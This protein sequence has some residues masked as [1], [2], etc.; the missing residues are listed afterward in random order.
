VSDILTPSDPH[1]QTGVQWEQEPGCTQ[2][3]VYACP[4]CAE[5]NGNTAQAKTPTSGIPTVL[6]LPFTVYRGFKCSPIGTWNE[7][8]DRAKRG[9]ENGE[10]RAV[11]NEIA[12]GTHS[13]SNA[14][15][16]ATTTDIT[17]TPGT[18]VSL[19]QGI[20]LLEQYMATNS[21]GQGVIMMTRRDVTLANA[22][23]PLIRPDGSVLRT[24][25]DTPVAALGGFNG[26]T[27]PNGVAAVGSN[28]WIFV[29]GRPIIRRS[30][31]FMTPVDREDALSRLNNDFVVLA[32]R[33]YSVNWDCITAGVLVTSI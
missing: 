17:P 14:L 10:E 33:T 20:A 12:L 4:T 24:T 22:N 13:V 30:E 9:L 21:H 18:A 23:S 27:G 29:T 6:A 25:L 2:A 1:W 5:N 26:R 11:E 7:G 15:V 32:E 31:I 28:A 8:M 3:S 19:V 16:R